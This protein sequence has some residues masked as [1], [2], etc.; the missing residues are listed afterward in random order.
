MNLNYLFIIADLFPIE[1]ERL[2]RFYLP[3]ERI[4]AITIR[5]GSKRTIASIGMSI[6]TGPILIYIY[7]S[8]F[9]TVS[10]KINQDL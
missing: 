1:H 4:N 7:S 10:R 6:S 8:P 2:I 3:L 5:V 9:D